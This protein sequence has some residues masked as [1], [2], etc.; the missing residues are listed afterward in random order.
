MRA[1]V[2]SLIACC[3]LACSSADTG[4]GG[5]PADPLETIA[6]KGGLSIEVRTAPNQPPVRGN[7]EVEYRVFDHA[8]MPVDALAITVDPW[9]PDM[10][11]GGSVTPD[12][13]DEGGGRY[14]VRNVSLFMPGRWQLRTHLG[15][16]VDD[17]ATATLQIP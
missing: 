4:S 8:K 3:T 6:S 13:T 15:G 14:V 12:V 11:H 5:F 2:L 16:P 7:I 17:D 10:A 1:L 9:M